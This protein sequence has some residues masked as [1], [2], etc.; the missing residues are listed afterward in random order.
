MANGRKRSREVRTH[1]TYGKSTLQGRVADSPHYSL[2]CG[3]SDIPYLQ[4]SRE[5]IS[6]LKGQ[7]I[8]ENDGNKVMPL[9]QKVDQ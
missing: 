4:G 1:S 7:N 3:P 5:A 8:I 9:G 2:P 6:E